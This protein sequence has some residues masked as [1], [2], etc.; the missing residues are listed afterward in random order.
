MDAGLSLLDSGCSTLANSQRV[1][2]RLS[3]R[4]WMQKSLCQTADAGFSLNNQWVQETFYETVDAV[5]SLSGLSISDSRCKT[6]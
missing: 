1:Q 5:F 3:M 2:E 4:L 6:L